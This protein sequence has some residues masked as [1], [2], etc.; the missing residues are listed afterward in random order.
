MD[1]QQRITAI[2]D[3]Y[4][5]AFKLK[6]LETWPELNGRS[7]RTLPD[8]VKAGIDRR[9]ITS[10]VLL[11][12]SAG[13][14]DEVAM[15]R[16]NVFERLNTGGIKLER[17]EIRNA[18]YRSP[19]NDMLDEITKWD[20]FRHVWGVPRF[21]EGEVENNPDLLRN[22]L[23]SKMGDSEIALRFFALRHASQYKRGMQGFLDLYAARARSF[24]DLDVLFLKDLYARTL[25][26]AFDVYREVLFQPFDAA[27]GDWSGKPQTAF[28]DAV[29]VGLSE[30]L[31]VEDRIRLR[32]ANLLEATKKLFSDHEPGT[33][34]GRGNT[35]A[36]IIERIEL[37]K[38]AVRGIL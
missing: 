6:G 14:E 10:I 34:T 3:F 21:V 28:H 8:K 9:S 12:E 13:D 24:T 29:M 31:D 4:D 7:Y 5:N 26:L 37:F 35:K 15:L 17:Q 20:R 36:D 27:T 38:S 11:K 33:F 2:K 19:F 25:N 18:I 23:F 32:S 30:F 1:G 22:T 16:Q